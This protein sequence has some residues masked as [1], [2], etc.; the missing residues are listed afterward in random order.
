VI[1]KMNMVRIFFLVLAL[2]AYSRPAPA[3][4]YCNSYCTGDV[5]TNECAYFNEPM[6]PGQCQDWAFWQELEY[7]C[8]QA[9]N[10]AGG[11][12]GWFVM[13]YCSEFM[14]EYSTTCSY[15]D[16]SCYE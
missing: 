5:R 16:N 3:W 15:H 10:A 11:G 2:G 13:T 14:G 7:Q 8:D 12:P 4:P 6:Y 1:T 9:A